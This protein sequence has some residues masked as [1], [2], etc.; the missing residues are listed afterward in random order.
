MMR[1][2]NKDSPLVQLTPLANT[3][4]KDEQEGYRFLFTG[5]VVA[6]RNPRGHEVALQDTP[7]Q[8]L[9]HLSLASLLLRRLE[10]S[11]FK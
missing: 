7:D 1:A 9:D 5:S 2:F 8:C 11:G 6:I 3:S 4:D 10:E